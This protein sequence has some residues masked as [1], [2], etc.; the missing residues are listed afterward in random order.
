MAGVF[1]QG[2]VFISYRRSDDPGFAQALY[3]RL[4]Q[5]FGGENLF[6][7]VEGQIKP[8]DDFVKVLNEQVARCDVLLAIIGQEWLNASDSAGSRRLDRPDDFVRVEIASALEL[9]KRVIPVLVN[10]AQMPRAHELP[11]GLQALS[12]RNAVVI[13]S[14]RFKADSQGLIDSVKAALAAAQAQRTAKTEAEQR[15]KRARD[16]GSRQVAVLADEYSNKI[17]DI[18][19]KTRPRRKSIAQLQQGSSLVPKSVAALAIGT[20]AL[21]IWHFIP[22][23]DKNLQESVTP[24]VGIISPK[25]IQKVI[26]KRPAPLAEAFVTV[27][28][29]SEE[30]IFIS[31]PN[32]TL[33]GANWQTTEVSLDELEP[34]LR[35]ITQ[36]GKGLDTTIFLRA[37]KSMNY[38]AVTRVMGRLSNAGFKHLSLVVDSAPEKAAPNSNSNAGALSYKFDP[39]RLA[40][41]L[42]VP[43]A[44]GAI[45]AGSCAA[46]VQSRV[47]Q[48]WI[49]PIG[50]VAVATT[51]IR[52]RIELR[53]DGTLLPPPTVMDPALSPT[54]RVMA[55][56]AVRAVESGQPFVIA[57][58]QYEQCR[59][60]ILRF[61]PRDMHGN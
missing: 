50:S 54:Q 16:G 23:R 19:S 22:G 17:Q 53:R 18:D 38:A 8:G 59:D 21:L 10:E 46:A 29:N 24:N 20:L 37:D 5:E 39:E 44:Q 40:S 36:A 7:D 33:P 28:M 35:I 2:K 55:D 52:L 13:R 58:Q 14:T 47:E 34:K 61:N 15:G 57:P 25:D 42:G 4:E 1:D 43:S 41:D 6:M 60:M 49:F 31:T 32:T 26:Q 56:A 48:N 27:T 12:R 11:E 51:D 9:S 45:N 3:L 30:K